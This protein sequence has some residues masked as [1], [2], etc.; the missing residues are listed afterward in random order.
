[1]VKERLDP[2]G[3]IQVAGELWWAEKSGEGPP[4]EEGEFVR[5]QKI[6]GLK[7]YVVTDNKA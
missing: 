1:M 7:L 6:E 2:S 3:Y 4:I 5:A